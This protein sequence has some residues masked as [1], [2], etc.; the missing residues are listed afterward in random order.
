MT[1]KLFLKY[2]KSNKSSIIIFGF[3]SFLIFKIIE[4][5]ISTFNIGMNIDEPFHLNQ[6]Q[7]WLNNFSYITQDDTVHSYTYGPLIGIL[8][9]LGNFIVGNGPINFYI[10]SPLTFQLNHLMIAGIGVIGSISFLLLNNKIKTAPKIGYL[11]I[12]LL[13][14]IP[15]WTGNSFH[16][17]KDTPSAVGYTLATLGC[18]VVTIS[19]KNNTFKIRHLVIIYFGLLFV[20]G[21]RPALLLPV[22]VTLFLSLFYVKFVLKK[23]STLLLKVF[24]LTMIPTLVSFFILL[25]QF[26][27]SPIE[28]FKTTFLTSTN[29]PWNGLIL[30]AGQLLEPSFNFS[31]FF[32][33]YFA[34]TPLLIWL[35]SII[36]LLYYLLIIV[37]SP[38]T[39]LFILSSLFFIQFSLL[40]LY[41]LLTSSPI[42]NGLRHI[43]FI[44][45]A[46]AFF[47]ALGIYFLLKVFKDKHFLVSVIVLIGIVVPNV[48]AI[49]L[50]PYQQVYYNPII[51][52]FYNVATDWETEYYGLSAR[53]AFQ[54][55]PSN[56][57]LAKTSDWV[58]EDPAFLQERGLRTSNVDLKETD[59]WLIS[60]IYSYTDG[61]SRQRMLKSKAPLEALK[62][63]CSAEYVVTRK[64]RLETIPMSFIARCQSSGKLLHGFASITYS[65]P[66]EVSA[67]QQP[68]FWL[69]TE[70]D[71]FRVTNITS[72]T[73][74]QN[75]TFSLFPNPCGTNASIYVKSDDNTLLINSP[76][77]EKGVEQFLIPVNILPYKTSGIELIPTGDLSCSLQSD[78]N[79]IFVSGVKDINLTN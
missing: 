16:N 24:L 8:L 33:W 14:S 48:E 19:L 15:L 35:F 61:D 31:Y 10:N 49:R 47:A 59:Y 71:S 55:L 18:F 74:S 77:D 23:S 26:I 62:P 32:K 73:I 78:D 45:P 29:F 6:A 4:L 13:M 12:V 25:P 11:S 75:F 69:T 79:R 42:Y 38:K 22:L 67:D 41:L 58:W 63:A 1:N 36:G 5:L 7:L 66:T 39:D 17:I 56:G 44:Y 40:P 57:N 68:Y 51:S 64:L 28:S 20:L 53:E 72:K 34:Q 70:G 46:I 9:S 27:S 2:F 37:R 3:I 30:T 52:L 60:G 65:S 54:H 43:L 50:L 21:T 76:S